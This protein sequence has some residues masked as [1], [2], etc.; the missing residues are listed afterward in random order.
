MAADRFPG[1]LPPL[2]YPTIMTSKFCSRLVIF[3]WVYGFLWFLILV[4]LLLSYH[5]VGPNVIDDF[6]CDLGPLLA[7]ASACVPIPG[8]VLICGTMSPLLIFATFFY[9]TGSYNLVLGL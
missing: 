6:L 3:C 9:I 7:L 1:N 8:T 4:I 5:F 2:H